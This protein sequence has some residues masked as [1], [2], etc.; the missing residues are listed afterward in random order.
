VKGEYRV[1]SESDI[2]LSRVSLTDNEEQLVA[3]LVADFSER[4]QDGST[5]SIQE[6][7]EKLPNEQTRRAFSRVAIVSQIVHL[8]EEV[9]RE[10]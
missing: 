5:V 3:D 6:Y 2:I 9:P 8:V 10:V 1:N 4:Q 7:L